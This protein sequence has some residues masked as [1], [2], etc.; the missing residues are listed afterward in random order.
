M[1]KQTISSKD[2]AKMI[3]K[4]YG[5]A[6]EADAFVPPGIARAMALRAM[7]WIG[8]PEEEEFGIE[9]FIDNMIEKYLDKGKF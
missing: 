5:R 9:Y 7:E 6:Q 2:I 3:R 8:S 4:V 1:A